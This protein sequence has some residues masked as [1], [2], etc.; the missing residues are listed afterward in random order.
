MALYTRLGNSTATFE[1]MMKRFGVVTVMNADVYEVSDYSLLGEM[2]AYEIYSFASA[3]AA[4]A[5]VGG[6]NSGNGI[7]YLCTLNTLKTA[8]VTIDGPNKTVT[9]GRYNNTLLK[10]GKSA[11]VEMTDALGNHEALDALCGTVSEYSTSLGSGL[12]GLHNTEDFASAKM[13]IGDSFF[14]DQK[15]GE[16]VP[17]KIM[18]YQFLPESLFN[19]T[20][21]AEGDATVFD[22]NGDLLTTEI[23]VGKADGSTEAHGVFWSVIDPSIITASLED[24]ETSKYIVY[25]D[26]GD[27]QQITPQSGYTLKVQNNSLTSMSLITYS[28]ITL[29]GD[30]GTT[31]VWVYSGDTPVYV[32]TFNG[33][34]TTP[35]Q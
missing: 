8:N 6:Q 21:D 25:T 16:Q 15:T 9:G 14:I 23:M 3:V 5:K 10:F 7:K 18:F 33:T 17:V 24:L 22:M 31:Q 1:Q 20:Q 27:T 2:N 30:T 35:E 19:L 28:S 12:V 29:S 26:L 11:T 32:R 13:I 34:I 4:S